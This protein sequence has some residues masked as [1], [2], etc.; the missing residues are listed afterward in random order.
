MDQKERDRRENMGD[1]GK[2]KDQHSEDKRHPAHERPDERRYA[3]GKGESVPP[4]QKRDE[5]DDRPSS[6]K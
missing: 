4:P 3:P 6:A 5:R 2:K 1:P